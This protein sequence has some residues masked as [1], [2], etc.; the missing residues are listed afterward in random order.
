MNIGKDF[1]TV[2]KSEQAYRLLEEQIVTM[3]IAPGA[4]LSEV[5][6]SQQLGIGRTPV[7]EALQRLANE[8]LVEIMPRRGIRVTEI[9]VK[10]Q[11]R[12]IEVR[13][14]L[15]GLQAQ[16]ASKRANDVQKERFQLLANNMLEQSE[17]NDYIGFVRSDREFNELLAAASDN[18]FAA[19]MLKQLHGLSR[20]FW[21]RHYQSAA[22]LQQVAALHAAVAEA[23]AAGAHN[24]AQAAVNAHMDYIQTF[25]LATL[26]G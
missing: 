26:E 16:L 10:Q 25:T 24:E 11:L 20:R 4:M 1:D 8:H 5:E 21:H 7:R 22:D 2:S 23:I 17:K 15:E 18:Q 19:T 9:N 3:T 6:L 12:L 14:E 13:R